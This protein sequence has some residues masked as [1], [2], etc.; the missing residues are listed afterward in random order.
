[1]IFPP[2]LMQSL[3]CNFELD[4]SIILGSFFHSDRLI[5]YGHD[6]PPA[7]NFEPYPICGLFICEGLS[8]FLITK[9]R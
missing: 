5:L 1:M 9:F 3:E 8:K 2:F 6:F 4:N 7:K